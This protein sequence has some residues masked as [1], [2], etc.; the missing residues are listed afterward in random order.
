[1]AFCCLVDHLEAIAVTS[2]SCLYFKFMNASKPFY[3][4]IPDSQRKLRMVFFTSHP[5]VYL[6]VM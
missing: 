2:S 3:V 1:M 6:F 4:S 5:V